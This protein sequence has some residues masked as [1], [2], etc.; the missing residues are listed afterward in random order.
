MMLAGRRYLHW[1]LVWSILVGL[2]FLI[3]G[4]QGALAQS[5]PPTGGTTQTFSPW[6]SITPDQR[7][8]AGQPGRTQPLVVLGDDPTFKVGEYMVYTAISDPNGMQIATWET[9][10][11]IT[12]R[13]GERWKVTFY[14]NPFPNE[15]IMA[16]E[17][18]DLMQYQVP[19]PG[20]AMIYANNS[21]RAHWRSICVLPIGAGMTVGS[22]C[23]RGTDNIIY[24][25]KAAGACDSIPG[26][27]SWF[28]NGDV[29]FAA[30][31]TLVQGPRTGRWTCNSATRQVTIVWSHGYTDELLLSPDGSRLTGRNNQQSSVAGQ[32]K[33][34]APAVTAGGQTGA[35]SGNGNVNGAGSC[36]SIPGLWSW[37]TNGDVTFA[38]GGTLVQGP[39]TGRWTC[40]SASRQVTIVWSHGYTDELLLSP[41]GTRLTGRNNQQGSVAGQRKSG[42]G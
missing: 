24:A 11:P 4:H 5:A 10:G 42:G 28:V 6:A 12:L 38:A 27:W 15:I 26:L 21:D 36:D 9:H 3:V 22:H 19:R 40:N 18:V 41:D 1:V 37:F 34:G 17:P 32:R 35:V 16:R 23:F 29:T 7:Q 31:G 2:A 8:S 25:P 20:R 30:G 33:A 14:Q 13:S 39:R